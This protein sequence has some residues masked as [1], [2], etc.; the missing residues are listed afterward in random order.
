MS[1]ALAD[2][3]KKHPWLAGLT[4]LLGLVLWLLPYGIKL[5]IEKALLAQGAQQASI[6]DIDLNLFQGQ[7]RLKHLQIRQDDQ[8]TLTIQNLDAAWRWRDLLQQHWALTDVHLQNATIDIRQTDAEHLTIGGLTLPLGASEDKQAASSTLPA[9]GIQTLRL[10][11]VSLQITPLAQP[12][13]RY[14]IQKLELNDLYSWQTEPAALILNSDLNGA[15]FNAHLQLDLFAKEPKVVGTIRT[16]QLNLA[17]LPLPEALK[18]QLP[19]LSGLLSTDLTFT[20][21]Q[22]TQG[23]QFNQQG[24]FSLDQV[25]LTVADLKTRLERISWSGD[26]AY[27]EQETN[28]RLHLQGKLQLA[29][30][31]LHDAAT[32]T[33]LQQSLDAELDLTAILKAGG[34]ALSQNGR[35]ILKRLNVEQPEMQLAL[36]SGQYQGVIRFEQND[37]DSN[38]D[39]TGKLTAQAVAL[40][41]AGQ[42]IQQNIDSDLQLQATLTPQSM[43]LSQNGSLQLK[44]VKW[45][46]A[47]LQ[48][49]LGKLLWQGEAAYRQLGTESPQLQA[50]GQ[51]QSENFRALS[52]Q[53]PIAD[54]AGLSIQKLELNGLDNLHLA[55]IRLKDLTLPDQPEKPFIQLGSLQIDQAALKNLDYL[56]IGHIHAQNTQAQLAIDANHQVA[57][58]T[59]LQQR[60]AA[61]TQP[62]ASSQPSEEKTAPAAAAFHYRIAAIQVDGQN[63]IQLTLNQFAEPISKQ[64]Q[65]DTL[66]I[67]TIDSQKP[68]SDTAVKLAA[69]IDEFATL[70]SQGQ[71]QPLNPELD[72]NLQSRIEGL[73]LV[74][75]SPASRQFVGYD[76]ASGQLSANFDT[77]IKNQQINAENTLKLNKLE[78]KAADADK[79]AEFQ[80]GLSMSLDAALGLLRDKEDNIK[81]KLPVKGD[82]SNP[83]FDLQHV[84]NTALS[85]AMKTATKTY[86]LLA[87]QPFG[88]IAL[89]GNFLTDQAGAIHLQ[90]VD[91]NAGESALNP[92]MQDYLQK[93]AKLLNEKRK[94]QIKVCAAANEY[95]RQI[96]L[97][98]LAKTLTEAK[99][100]E[101]ADKTP[102]KALPAPQV[103]DEELL[104]L[105]TERANQIK[106]QLLQLGVKTEQ[107]ILC[108]P[109]LDADRSPPKV[110]LGI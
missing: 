20:A 75:L 96:R 7:F 17:Q 53:Q 84:I 56:D 24:N 71:L 64:L 88:A 35:L 5:G 44:Q 90:A 34:I 92:Q 62:M 66:S 86:L 38:L 36:D 47:H 104:N 29:N 14:H 67:G 70:S 3:F 8:P 6:D 46:Q 97:H 89:A 103:S 50:K 23:V 59:R 58:I 1:N 108:Q 83:D 13:S 74:D 95:D 45:Q 51:V 21:Q 55:Q 10:E 106:R 40:K 94:I 15:R 109:R 77:Q 68:Q 25:A 63:P 2:F 27:T 39:M 52:R 49:E 26:V 79:S 48:A 60:L 82:L 78:L 42:T 32:Q 101:K 54:L 18:A 16:Q 99:P 61:D 31:D 102:A 9:V 69:R 33:A 93:L 22:R 72:V 76:I 43:Q 98:K 81:L 100:T 87:L 80:Q 11:N 12:A 57:E 105:A 73:N 30:L 91:F 28:P 107:V 65:V 110:T 41:Q 19:G 37:A 4:V 85:G